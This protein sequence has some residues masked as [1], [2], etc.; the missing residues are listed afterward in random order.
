MPV[1]A[2]QNE[3][4]EFLEIGAPRDWGCRDDKRMFGVLLGDDT[5][6]IRGNA[7]ICKTGSMCQ[8]LFSIKYSSTRIGR[9]VKGRKEDCVFLWQENKN[10]HQLHSTACYK[11]VRSRRG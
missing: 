2:K 10:E 1:L 9:E 3:L 5:R 7:H 6:A 4:W 11:N 8:H